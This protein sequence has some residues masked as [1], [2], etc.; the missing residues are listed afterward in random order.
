MPRDDW[1]HR[2]EILTPEQIE[3]AMAAV[4]LL[5]FFLRIAQPQAVFEF[6]DFEKHWHALQNT[7]LNFEELTQILRQASVALHQLDDSDLRENCLTTLK[8]HFDLWDNQAIRQIAEMNQHRWALCMFSLRSL[9]LEPSS[10]F[11]KAWY[12]KEEYK[13]MGYD[14]RKPRDKHSHI[15]ALVSLALA[16]LKPSQNYFENWENDVADK[17]SDFLN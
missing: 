1:T 3:R 17:L 14:L 11:L 5:H 9:G 8:C 13:N 12:D 7:P 4:P 6:S 10:E 16:N 2:P 15:R